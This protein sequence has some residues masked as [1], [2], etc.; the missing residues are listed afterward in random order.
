MRVMYFIYLSLCRTSGVSGPDTLWRVRWTPLLGLKV[1]ISSGHDIN[2]TEYDDTRGEGYVSKYS[3][4]KRNRNISDPDA[5]TLK[6][7][8]V[9]SAKQNERN[10]IEYNGKISRSGWDVECS[11]IQGIHKNIAPTKSQDI[12]SDILYHNFSSPT[13]GFRHDPRLYCMPS[14][15]GK[16]IA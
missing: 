7:S 8:D 15:R 2:N 6:Y 11:Q 5:L 4:K 3:G 16:A 14:Q 1:I 13:S 10:R 12:C 9:C